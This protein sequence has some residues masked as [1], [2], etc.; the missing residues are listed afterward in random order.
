MFVFICKWLK[1]AVF[2]RCGKRAAVWLNA[3][4][5]ARDHRFANTGSGQTQQKKLLWAQTEAKPPF[6][7]AFPR[8]CPEPVLVKRSYS[9]IEWLQKS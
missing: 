9:Y 4:K 6:V 8:V 1:N 7:S 5:T 3:F 2:R